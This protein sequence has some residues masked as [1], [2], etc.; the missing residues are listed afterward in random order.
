MS[1]VETDRPPVIEA[2]DMSKLYVQRGAL[3]RPA[4]DFKAASGVSLDI[5]RGETLALV[6]SSGC[7]KTTVARMLLGLIEPDDGEIRYDGVPAAS[8][9]LEMRARFAQIVFQDPYAS[10]NP[11][12][13]VGSSIGDPLRKFRKSE[14]RVPGTSVARTSWT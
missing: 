2:I 3:R 13:T 10:L 4:M 6:G 14:P 5:R 9:S 7:G 12:R 1:G 8:F 11:R